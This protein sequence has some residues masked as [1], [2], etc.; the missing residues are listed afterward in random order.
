MGP[1]TWEEIC[2]DP[3]LRKLPHKLEQDRFGRVIVSQPPMRRHARLQLAICD[4]LRALL[5]G[6]TAFPECSV[7][8]PEGFRSPDA[9]A[10][11]PGHLERFDDKRPLPEAPEICVE[12]LS[13]ANSESEMDEKRRLLAAVGCQEFWT[14]DEDGRMTF[15]DGD[16]TRLAT[17]RRCPAFPAVISLE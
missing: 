11:P 15:F 8:T 1:M 6:W 12:V 10:S 14:C 2:A 9:A 13:P 5:P 3:D 16:G 7:Q 17:S 4:L